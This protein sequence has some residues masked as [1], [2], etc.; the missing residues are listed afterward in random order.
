MVQEWP[1]ATYQARSPGLLPP[2]DA[3]EGPPTVQLPLGHDVAHVLLCPHGR[4]GAA[5]RDGQDGVPSPHQADCARDQRRIGA[6]NRVDVLAK[7]HAAV[8]LGP[9]TR[10]EVVLRVKRHAEVVGPA[11]TSDLTPPE[12]SR[13][14]LL[15]AVNIGTGT[16]PPDGVGGL[17]NGIVSPV[18]FPSFLSF[19][20]FLSL[21]AAV[22]GVLWVAVVTLVSLVHG[23]RCVV[24]EGA[25]RIVVRTVRV[26]VDTDGVVVGAVGV[27]V[28]SRWRVCWVDVS[29]R[30]GWRRITWCGVDVSWRV[31]RWRKKR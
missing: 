6:V 26:V 2:V 20:A 18:A 14:D 31:S 5:C 28:V 1:N 29:R 7:S 13:V 12:E 30:V 23:R 17:P 27:A 22:F 11:P 25:V 8:A 24:V 16:A 15:G 4:A 10:W 9:L 21:V 3:L 19:V